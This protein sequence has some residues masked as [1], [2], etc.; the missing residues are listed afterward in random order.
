MAYLEMFVRSRSFVF[1]S[2]AVILARY[3]HKTIGDPHRSDDHDIHK[4]RY[5]DH[6]LVEQDEFVVL[7]K[8]VLDQVGFDYPHEVEVQEAIYQ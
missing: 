6:V 5:Y 8:S 7:F 3:L 2:G 4:Q 1:E